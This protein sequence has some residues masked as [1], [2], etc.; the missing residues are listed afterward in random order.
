MCRS[1]RYN[2]VTPLADKR[3]HHIRGRVPGNKEGGDPMGG[4]TPPPGGT[5][6]PQPEVN[7]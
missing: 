4:V 6:P 3:Q 7:A 5:D 1:A 2:N